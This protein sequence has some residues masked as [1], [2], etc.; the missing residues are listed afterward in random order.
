[1]AILTILIARHVNGL[2]LVNLIIGGFLAGPAGFLLLVT[3]LDGVRLVEIGLTLAYCALL[4]VLSAFLWWH[5]VE[6]YRLT[7]G[8]EYG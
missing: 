2:T 3:L 6:K 1:M 7:L 4:G 5:I 8:K